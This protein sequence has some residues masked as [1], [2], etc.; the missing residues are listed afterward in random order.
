MKTARLNASS[1]MGGRMKTRGVTLVELL[2]AMAVG[3]LVVAV[4]VDRK[5]VV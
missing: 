1:S 3:L 4:S 2:V 5:S